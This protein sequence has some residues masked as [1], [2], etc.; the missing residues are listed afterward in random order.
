[1]ETKKCPYCHEDIKAEAVKCRYCGEFIE[2]ETTVQQPKPKPSEVKKTYTP[3]HSYNN[4]EHPWAT[5]FCCWVLIVLTIVE[6]FFFINKHE[7]LTST[8]LYSSGWLSIASVINN[9]LTCIAL[10]GLHGFCED[11]NIDGGPIKILISLT[12]VC[13]IIFPIKYLIFTTHSH[14]LISNIIDFMYLPLSIVAI[15]LYIM[16][17]I[18]LCKNSI[19]RVLGVIIIS[20]LIIAMFIFPILIG[21]LLAG[22]ISADIFLYLLLL[23]CIIYVISYYG[24]LSYIITRPK[25][26][27]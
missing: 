23:M 13:A 5:A 10:A 27:R 9:V 2:T 22:N 17:G 14:L 11:R 12:A 8:Y 7:F 18:K 3:K 19:T 26:D 21:L 16:V 1:M 15:V 24:A 4:L 6:L 25:N 20:S